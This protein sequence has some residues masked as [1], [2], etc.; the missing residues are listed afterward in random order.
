MGMY[1]KRILRLTSHEGDHE[2]AVYVLHWASQDCSM[3][4][5][6]GGAEWN[7]WHW[8]R[9]T[10]QRQWRYFAIFALSVCRLLPV[11]LG[12]SN[13]GE[14]VRRIGKRGLRNP[15]AMLVL[16]QYTAQIFPLCSVLSAEYRARRVCLRAAAPVPTPSSAQTQF[17]LQSLSTPA[18]IFASCESHLRQKLPLHMPDATLKS[19]NQHSES[20]VGPHPPQ[21]P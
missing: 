2:C 17:E 6:V 13:A 14:V 21:P 18:G 16:I 4:G 8:L 15:V 5:A 10:V 1:D 20:F 19:R 3:I 12:M 11:G 9:C 7:E